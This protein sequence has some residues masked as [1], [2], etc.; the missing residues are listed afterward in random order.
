MLHL[1]GI[2][3]GCSRRPDSRVPVQD[4]FN[5]L[6]SISP[7]SLKFLSSRR[8]LRSRR[9]VECLKIRVKILEFITS[10]KISIFSK[11]LTRKITIIHHLVSF[12][13]FLEIFIGSSLNVQEGQVREFPKFKILK[14]LKFKNILKFKL[15]SRTSKDSRKIS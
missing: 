2:F 5:S 10:P 9:T 4:P 13:I 8:S 14:F 3:F 12:R 7:R 1:F 11:C 6:N 15:N